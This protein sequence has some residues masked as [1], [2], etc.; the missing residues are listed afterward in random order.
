[1]TETP[2]PRQEGA[3]KNFDSDPL[4]ETSNARIGINPVGGYVTTWEVKNPDGRFFPVLHVGSELKRTGIPALFPNY[5][6]SGGDVVTH[7][8]GR[9]STWKRITQEP[10][11]NKAVMELTDEDISDEE[12]AKYPYRFKATIE[13]E[14]DEDGSLVHTMKVKNLGR[15]PLPFAGGLHPYDA[16]LHEQKQNITTDIEGFD[17]S[18]I[19]WNNDP[20][21]TEYNFPG[22]ATINLPDKTLTITD[23]SPLR[24]DGRR[25]VEKIVVW[26]KPRLNPENDPAKPEDKDINTV[27]F[28]PVTRGTK[29]L[30]RDPIMVDPDEELVMKIRF[31]AVQ[32]DQAL[33]A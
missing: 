12:R 9:T 31:S 8:F 15:T 20:P 16:V 23:E 32:R 11:S 19:D 3:Q 17:A 7:G 2:V 27:C 10:G 25:V 28:E 26:A 18:N 14:A 21:D 30:T 33:A 13:V 1:M 29:G 24:P 5:D 22:K 4:I 6:E